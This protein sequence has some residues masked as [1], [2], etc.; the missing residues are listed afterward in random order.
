MKLRQIKQR[1]AVTKAEGETLDAIR[2]LLGR[3]TYGPTL[4]EIA[5][6]RGCSIQFIYRLVLSLEEKR[7]LTF[8]RDHNNRMIGRSVKLLDAKGRVA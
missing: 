8:Q 3:Y 4:S 7:W 1:T 6:E 2:E 5:D